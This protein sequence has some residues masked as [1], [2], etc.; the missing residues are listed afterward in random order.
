MF[1]F[2]PGSPSKYLNTFSKAQLMTMTWGRG[3]GNDDQGQ[4]I[5]ADP[6]DFPRVG[7]L[8]MEHL[9]SLALDVQLQTTSV[10]WLRAISVG[11][12]Y[13]ILAAER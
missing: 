8:G 1:S 5:R 13:F 7:A 9:H 11:M 6:R 3:R 12:L 10:T 2:C 4:T